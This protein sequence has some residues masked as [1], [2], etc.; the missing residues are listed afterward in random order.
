MGSIDENALNNMSLV[1]NLTKNIHLKQTGSN[2]DMDPDDYSRYFPNFMW[3]IR[4]FTLQ[5]TDTDGEPISSKE[6][7]EKALGP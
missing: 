5:L 7:L 6:Y 4:D 1:I 2:E 3:V